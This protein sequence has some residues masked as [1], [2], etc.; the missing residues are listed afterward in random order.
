M[1]FGV[2]PLAEAE[3]CVLAHGL[4]L[5]FSKLPKGKTITAEDV[6]ALA[7]DG[8]AKV[9]AVRLDPQDM[10]E[11]VAAEAIA[12]AFRGSNTRRSD[13]ATGRVNIYAEANGVLTV[14]RT[15]VDALN[16][17]D[18]AITFA[19][20]ADHTAI[21]AGDMVA[22]VKIIP[23]AV[24]SAKVRAAVAL[25]QGVTTFSVKPYRPHR[26][27]LIAT[28]LPTLK[29]SVMDRTA[30]LL[31]QRLAPSASTLVGEVRTN[32][33]TAMLTAA[34]RTVVAEGAEKPDLIVIFGASAVADAEDVIPAAIRAA[35]GVVEHVGMPVDPGNLLVLGKIGTV[36]V[37][38]A[39][40][41]ARSPKENGFD[42]VLDRILIGE[43][44]T[45]FD[46]T[47]MGVGGLLKEI[48][49]R[50]RPRELP[51]TEPEKISVGALLLAA[52]E[53]RRMGEGGSHKLLASFDGRPL[54]RRSAETLI[55]AR[56]EPVVTI[57]GHRHEEIE[58]S[59]QGLGVTI[60]FNGDY[61]SGM[62]S[63]LVCALSLP[64][65]NTCDGVLVMLADMPAV[66]A[67]HIQ[68]MAEAF[69]KAGGRTVVRAV[70]KGKRGNP[71]ILPRATFDAVR[72]LRGDVGARAIVENCGLP[73]IDV[74]IGPAAHL[75]VD[76]PE[77]VIG[78]GGKLRE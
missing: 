53:A 65:L 9:T 18:P 21:R 8:I 76:T 41:C 42:W 14:D 5:S 1:Q 57:S 22:T 33:D 2:F 55:A 24:P 23:L 28:E 50:P 66:T 31:A 44:P 71:I 29:T 43:P 4:R 20:L 61:R 59:L 47:G 35:G 56:M 26:V 58:V 10:L 38:G 16:R 37:L 48:P 32:H 12:S 78:A 64:A 19:T 34:M 68:Q 25:V 36:P 39:P 27:M 73:I 69:R 7:A 13:A 49:D 15:A 63:S 67:G 11:D 17:I 51:S 74:E 70:N 60:E 30:R 40:G 52:G 3:G 46:L 77:A 75:D 6:Q 72:K 45:A 54:V 62:A